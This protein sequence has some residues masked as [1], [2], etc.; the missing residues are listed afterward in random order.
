MNTTRG[1]DAMT[2]KSRKEYNQRTKLIAE[3]E[4]EYGADVFY[5]LMG[6]IAK[7]RKQGVDIEGEFDKAI[8]Q[9]DMAA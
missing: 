5:Q 6:K 7:L 9:A 8:K 3:F 1:G 4:K 2:M